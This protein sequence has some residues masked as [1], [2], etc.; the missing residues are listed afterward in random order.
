MA[1]SKD[2]SASEAPTVE[3]RLDRIEQMISDLAGSAKA[4]DPGE[5]KTPKLSDDEWDA[6]TDRGKESWVR[7]LV[8]GEIERVRAADKD[9]QRDA[10]I[11]DLKKKVERPEPE[12]AP[13][14]TTRI[15][16][17]LWGAEPKK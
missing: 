10:E 2:P 6:L 12:R 3:D 11:D 13:S 4:P 17:W 7:R 15:Q 8:E 14:I 16:E 9:R 5:A 1:T